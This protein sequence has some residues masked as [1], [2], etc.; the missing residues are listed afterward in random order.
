MVAFESDSRQ[1]ARIGDVQKAETLMSK[2]KLAKKEVSVL[3]F[4]SCFSHR[5]NNKKTEM[6]ASVQENKSE[7]TS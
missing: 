6:I 3:H 1:L 5:K 4:C 7:H 2:C